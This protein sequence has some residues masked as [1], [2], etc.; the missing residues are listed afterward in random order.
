MD[1][2]RVT[3]VRSEGSKTVESLLGP[4]HWIGF[5]QE[6]KKSDMGWAE[7]GRS[8]KPR[9]EFIPDVWGRREN[10]KQRVNWTRQGEAPSRR[11]Q[12]PARRMWRM[13]KLLG[14]LGW[15]GTGLCINLVRMEEQ[16][17]SK[18]KSISDLLWYHP[19][20]HC[21]LVTAGSQCLSCPW[22]K[23]V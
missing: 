13:E 3:Q 22:V 21:S 9:Q 8:Y 18:D 12:K 23:T 14:K 19:Q 2:M 11:P 7:G 16:G 10:K 1:G 17:D 6:G 4:E 15:K 5:R 20:A